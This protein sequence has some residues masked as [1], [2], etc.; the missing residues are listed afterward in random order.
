MVK[1]YCVPQY[2]L[3]RV[4]YIKCILE[5]IYIPHYRVIKITAKCKIQIYRQA[6][7]K[8]TKFIE[9]VNWSFNNGK[10]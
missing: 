5:Q 8:E 9:S 2:H 1:I 10:R 4:S 3:I 6:A 7:T